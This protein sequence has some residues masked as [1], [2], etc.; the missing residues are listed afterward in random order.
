ML[1]AC[2]RRSNSSMQAARVIHIL[3]EI[4]NKMQLCIRIYYSI[5]LVI[6][7][8]SYYDARIHEY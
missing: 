2:H 8:K 6:S 7:T 4:T 5:L 1:S 3:V